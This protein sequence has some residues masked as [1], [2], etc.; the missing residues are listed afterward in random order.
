[1]ES[2]DVEQ[3]I[4]GRLLDYGDIVVRGTG[5][6]LEPFRGIGAPLDFRNHV[7]AG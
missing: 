3:S 2:V 7:T 4:L 1:V 6:T 5:A